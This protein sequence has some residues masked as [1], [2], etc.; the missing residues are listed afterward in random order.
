MN[1]RRTIATIAMSLILLACFVDAGTAQKLSLEQLS[2]Q[3]DTIVHGRVSKTKSESPSKRGFATTHVL[4]AVEDQFKGDSVSSVTIELP[5]GSIGDLMQGAPGIP[6]FTTGEEV[7]VFLQR[8]KKAA[9]YRVVGGKQG[10]FSV[11]SDHHNN[12]KI[13]EDLAHRLEPY[14][15]FV[16]R[17]TKS[18]HPRN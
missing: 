16:A 3:A 1:P 8:Q 13:V 17:L 10:K 12:A 11:R 5:V 2:L 6:E 14:E 4:I 15:K 9:D 18:L 7:I